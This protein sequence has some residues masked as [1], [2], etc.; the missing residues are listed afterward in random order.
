MLF[1]ILVPCS[2]FLAPPQSPSMLQQVYS[3]CLLLIFIFILILIWIWFYLLLTTAS[4]LL[5][6]LMMLLL[7][8]DSQGGTGA[9][10]TLLLWVWVQASMVSLVSN[11]WINQ[12]II[13]LLLLPHY[14]NNLVWTS[15]YQINV[16]SMT[17]HHL[18]LWLRWQIGDCG[19]W[20]PTHVHCVLILL[21]MH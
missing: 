10:A 13:K 16:S 4:Y 17:Y 14:K 1:L 15:Q 3:S 2:K 18:L 20:W 19:Q 21:C 12:P 6:P 11:N 9:G 5:L 7:I 8:A